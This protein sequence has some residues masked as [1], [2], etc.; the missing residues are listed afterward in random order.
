MPAALFCTEERA[1]GDRAILLSFLV[2]GLLA[3]RKLLTWEGIK[4][5]LSATV[6]TIV[7]ELASTFP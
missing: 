2:V 1:L 5:N 3:N 6:I 7:T 4:P